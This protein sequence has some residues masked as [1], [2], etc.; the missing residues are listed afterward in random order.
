MAVLP[1][2]PNLLE[3]LAILGD[4]GLRISE[5]EA[6][7]GAA[8]NLSVFFRWPVDPGPVFPI[9]EVIELP[10]KVPALAGGSVIMS[11]SGRRLREIHEEPVLNLGFLNI[12]ADGETAHLFTSPAKRFE[13]LSSEYNSHLAIHNDQVE[14]G[15]SNF[16]AVVHA[17]PRFLTYLSHIASYRDEQYLNQHLLR[18]QP[19]LIVNLPEGIGVVPFIVP[20]TPALMKATVEGLRGHR[21]VTWS[22]HGVVARSEVSIKRAIDRIEYAE[23]GAHYEYLNLANHNIAEGLTPEE[24]RAICETWNVKQTIF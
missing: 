5:I 17:Q 9:D 7:E 20:G 13:R 22:K 23:A 10:V 15:G 19:E 14:T 3:L 1:P 4:A 24:I 8:G 6:S 21:I 12:N 18:W 2:F 16:H 11:G